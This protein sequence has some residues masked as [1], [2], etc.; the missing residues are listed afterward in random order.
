MRIFLLIL[1]IVASACPVALA[2]DW[3]DLRG[4]IYYHRDVEV[5]GLLDRGVSVNLVGPGG[6]TPLMIAAADGDVKMVEY[7]LKRGADPRA[8]T[9]SGQTAFDVTGSSQ[10][11]RL[12]K[13]PVADPIG[14]NGP[15][16]KQPWQIDLFPSG[17]GAGADPKIWSNARWNIEYNQMDELERVLDQDGLDVNATG[18]DGWTLL[19]TAAWTDKPEFVAFLLSRGADPR[20]RNAKGETAASLTASAAIIDLLGGTAQ[21]E[22]SQQIAEDSIAY[23]RDLGGKAYMLCGRDELTCRLTA[24]NNQQSCEATGVWP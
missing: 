14:R 12:V 9:D 11:K 3:D 22:P 8:Q 2:D 24:L 1:A 17:P 18:P 20:I 16:N 23:C 10:I 19:M 4:A 15:S 21:A 5:V 6:W 7:L 13:V